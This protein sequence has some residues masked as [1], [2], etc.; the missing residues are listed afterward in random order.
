MIIIK[1]NGIK[2]AAVG[3][4]SEDISEE[5]FRK[6]KKI[7]EFLGRSNK[8]GALTC[9]GTTGTTRR[10]AEGA[11]S[12]GLETIGYTPAMNIEEHRE[13][14][15]PVEPYSKL[16][17]ITEYLQDERVRDLDKAVRFKLRVP[18]LITNS[19]AVIA[20]SGRVGTATEILNAL[21][22]EIPIGVLRDSGGI[23]EKIVNWIDYLVDLKD[24]DYDLIYERDPKKLVEGV[25][26]ALI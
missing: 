19:D 8:I 17:Y 23:S 20:V 1:S 15:L 26:N 24:M 6:A 3:S 9:G 25:V 14:G 2:I 11:K 5:V 10:V 7:G 21:D 12:E 16:V 18:H 22:I 4:A 13:F